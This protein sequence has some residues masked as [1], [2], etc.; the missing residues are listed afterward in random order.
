MVCTPS[1]NT[2]SVCDDFTK[3]WRLTTEHSLFV[4]SFTNDGNEEDE[5]QFDDTYSPGHCSCSGLKNENDVTLRPKQTKSAAYS[6]PY[7]DYQPES[8]Q[9]E[10]DADANKC[11]SVQCLD[12]RGEDITT[13]LMDLLQ[14][15][16]FT[17]EGEEFGIKSTEAPLLP[18]FYGDSP[19]KLAL[20]AN[21]EITEDAAEVYCRGVIEGMPVTKLCRDVAQVDIEAH[22]LSCRNEVV[23][24]RLIID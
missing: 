15:E 20:E 21:G 16:D 9:N 11:N 19:L 14:E 5:S 10:E 2:T 23:V 24:S 6:S 13:Q 7:D 22:I 17:Y 8:E 12:S 4:G 3:S 1:V 18:I